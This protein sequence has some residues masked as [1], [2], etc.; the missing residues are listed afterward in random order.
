MTALIAA[1]LL[2]FVVHE[3]FRER[4]PEPILLGRP[5]A[6][7]RDWMRAHRAIYSRPGR[8]V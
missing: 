3:L 1:A 5:V 2:F 7:S 8:F 4:K 6:D